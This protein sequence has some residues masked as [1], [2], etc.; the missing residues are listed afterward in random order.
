MARLGESRSLLPFLAGIAAGA[1]GAALVAALRPRERLDLR[2]IRDA[3][4]PS[5]PPT[6]VIPGILGSGLAHPDGRQA[7][8]NLGNTVGYH[9]LG[10]PLRLPLAE[11]RDALAP[12]G[13]VGVDDVLPRLFGFTEYADLVD[14]LERGGFERGGTDA[15][16]AAYHVF[17]YDWRRD[18]VE[19]A[20]RLDETLEALAEAYGDPDLR[21]N[22]LGHSMGGLI[23]RYY[24]R[25]GSAEPGGPV[26]WAGARRIRLLLLSAVP[27]GGSPHAL[28]SLLVG[29]RVGLSATTLSAAVLWRMPAL[30]ELLPPPGTVPLVDASGRALEDDVQDVATWHRRHWGPFAPRRRRGEADPPPAGVDEEA[31]VAA[32]LERAGRFHAAL[33]AE[34]QTPCPVRVVALGSDTLPTLARAVVD[35]GVGSPRF[36]PR[37]RAQAEIMLEAGDGRVTRSSA[38]AAHL[39]SAADSELGCGIPEVGATHFG[40]ADH[41]GLYAEPGFQSLLLRLLLRPRRGE[42]GR[43]RA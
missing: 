42:R 12:A 20:R 39:A 23:A 26:T 35:D 10:L 6:V 30:Y 22:V 15:A 40:S 31:F 3:R 13:L 37:S 7:W 21:L 41:H 24:L 34:P 32:A 29:E 27:S 11:S 16:R 1:A 17:A 38:L 43:G 9:D 18:L 28:E 4:D 2:L 19:S 25:Y 8:L 33:A 5:G 36:E 14:L